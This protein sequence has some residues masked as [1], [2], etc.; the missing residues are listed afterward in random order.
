M[1]KRRV[2]VTGPGGGSVEKGQVSIED[3]IAELEA[4]VVAVEEQDKE[5]RSQVLELSKKL[6]ELAERS[7]LH[8]TGKEFTVE[9]LPDDD[10]V[11]GY[12][13]V[14]PR[15]ISLAYRSQLDD[16]N[17][18]D[19]EEIYYK[20]MSPSAW[21]LEWLREIPTK[22]RLAELVMALTTQAKEH[23][24]GNANVVANAARA[25]V[26]PAAKIEE[27]LQLVVGAAAGRNYS[28]VLAAWGK[29][30]RAIHAEPDAAIRRASVLLET[31][32]K[33]IYQHYDLQLPSDKTISGLYHGLKRTLQLSADAAS[34]QDLKGIVTAVSTV[35]QNLGSH[36]TKTGDAHGHGPDFLGGSRAQAAL[37]VNLAGTLSAFLIRQAEHVLV[38]RAAPT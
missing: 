32:M 19:A 38:P 8:A 36:R 23:L 11:Y 4:A 17:D 14:G 37:S 33:H 9:N 24:A 22:R 1:G 10:R 3:R 6:G 34:E 26:Q 16:Y 15:G 2:G 27:E 29:A 30:Q 25:N 5:L 20:T 35:V 18:V 31:T 13:S 21:P 12:L 7:Q 28:A